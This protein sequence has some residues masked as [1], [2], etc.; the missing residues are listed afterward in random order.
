MIKS[1]ACPIDGRC[2]KTRAALM[3]HKRMSHAMQA[4]PLPRQ[5]RSQPPRRGAKRQGLASRLNGPGTRTCR[6]SDM[7]EVGI[8]VST[9][10]NIGTVIAEYDITP[11]YFEGTRFE[12]ESRLWAR[13]RPTSLKVGVRPSAGSMTSGAYAV[14]FTFDPTA[15]LASAPTAVSVVNAMRPS[16][17]ASISQPINLVLPREPSQK[18][19]HIQGREKHDMIHGRLFV[20]LVSKIGNVT[21][22]SRISFNVRLDWTCQFEG[23]SMPVSVEQ[24]HVYADAGFEGY[25]T[26]STND[27]ANGDRLSVKHTAGGALVPFSDAESD[28]LYLLD[29][30]AKLPYKTENGGGFITHAVVIRDFPGRHFA[31]FADQASALKYMSSGNADDCLKYYSAGDAINPDN[32]PWTAVSASNLKIARLECEL[33]ALRLQ[34]STRSRIPSVIS[35]DPSDLSRLEDLDNVKDF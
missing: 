7:L 24:Q 11:K 4:T 21:T 13:W 6:G 22:D 35:E 31:V 28:T 8:Q 18:W 17:T 10:T 29:K 1:H 33:A 12:L 16:A 27:W 9:S 14:G 20:V 34:V 30:Q 32:P 2:F 19:Y 15:R 26:T 3:Q 5:P 25:H 23:M